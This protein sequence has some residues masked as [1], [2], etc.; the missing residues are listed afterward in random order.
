[1]THQMTHFLVLFSM[2]LIS[3]SNTEGDKML[4]DLSVGILQS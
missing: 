4:P 3:V 2:V 1:M